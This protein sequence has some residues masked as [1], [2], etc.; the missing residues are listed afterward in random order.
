MSTTTPDPAR[1]ALLV[2]PTDNLE[3]AFDLHV[4]DEGVTAGEVVFVLLKLA[5][6][7]QQAP[8]AVLPTVEQR[9]AHL[10]EIEH[11]KAHPA[12]AFYARADD[13]LWLGADALAEARMHETL[14]GFGWVRGGKAPDGVVKG[15]DYAKSPEAFWQRAAPLDAP[16][17]PA[18]Q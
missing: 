13:V 9:K 11:A 15:C 16:T 2:K 8:N 14:T 18:E 4:H 10:A 12:K 17:G 5:Q 6:H 1:W 7:L 3:A